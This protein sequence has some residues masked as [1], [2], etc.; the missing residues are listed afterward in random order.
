LLS[1]VVVASPVVD[2]ALLSVISSGAILPNP[3]RKPTQST[4]IHCQTNP[5][6]RPEDPSH[7]APQQVKP[8]A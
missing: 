4:A 5:H 7:L 1:P 3:E 8:A 2:V 6:F